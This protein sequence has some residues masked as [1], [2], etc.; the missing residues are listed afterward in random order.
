MAL[1]VANSFW[2]WVEEGTGIEFRNAKN[3]P[4]TIL[5][6]ND[7]PLAYIRSTYLVRFDRVTFTGGGV[8][9]QQ[10]S[11]QHATGGNWIF[12][13]TTCM[14]DS[15]TP[16]FNVWVDPAVAFFVGLEAITVID[17]MN[18]DAQYGPGGT[19]PMVPVIGWNVTVQ[20][21]GIDGVTLMGVSGPQVAGKAPA[22]N[23]AVLATGSN[24]NILGVLVLDGHN[25]GARD[26]VDA[27]GNA[28]GRWS[29]RNGGGGWTTVTS[30]SPTFDAAL[31][32]M[33]PHSL[34]IGR[35]GD[36][37]ASFAVRPDGTM[38]WG[39]GGEKPFDTVIRRPISHTWSW[40]PGVVG[41]G[42]AISTSVSVGDCAACPAGHWCPACPQPT[43][44]AAATFSNLG[45]A[46]AQ[47][48]AHVAAPGRVVVV[49][50]NAGPAD[51]NLTAGTARVLVTT[52][53][54]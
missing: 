22:V 25:S 2:V 44:L 19:N 5:R 43:D 7:D 33:S 9:Y 53:G 54:E 24:Q 36:R 6:G 8:E 37:T 23:P 39:D 16:L 20:G 48:T 31:S 41:I 26:V 18:A 4:S 10:L 11:E 49:L 12:F 38:M 15:T 47:V 51:L 50:R 45:D 46:L 13:Q 3:L 30:G 14:E 21:G 42:D 28:I 17:F 40:T 35:G 1:L 34:T 32:T 52:F 27:K 29:A